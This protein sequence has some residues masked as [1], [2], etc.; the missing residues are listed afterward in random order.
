MSGRTPVHAD[1]KLHPSLVRLRRIRAAAIVALLTS[2][3]LVPATPAHAWPTSTYTRIF[4]SAKRYLP[5]ALAAFLTDFEPALSKPC[6]AAAAETA[7]KT[8][9][10]NLS[11]KN[12]D[13]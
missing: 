12:G 6:S 11:Q 10:E 2:T 9:I 7:A 4:G 1:Q 3:F 5:P 8:A 13:L